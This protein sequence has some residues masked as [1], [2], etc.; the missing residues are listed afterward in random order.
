MDP[1]VERVVARL[2]GTGG[3]SA[4]VLGGSRA[5]GSATAESDYDIGLYSSRRRGPLDI[6]TLRRAVADLADPGSS[7]T[8]TEPGEW[9]RW[10]VGGAWLRVDGRPVDLLY[11]NIDAVGSVIADCTHGRLEVDYQPG[12][13][14]CFVSSIWMAEVAQCQVLH[15]ADGEMQ[16]LKAAVTPYPP[17]LRQATLARFGWECGFAVANAGK[18]VSRGDHGYIAGSLFRAF[19]CMA[20]ALHALNG[21]YLMNEKGALAL[22]ANLPVT[23]PR[24]A[25]RA[26]GVWRD[27]GAGD[28]ARALATATSLVA[29]FEQLVESDDLTKASLE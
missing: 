28:Y 5:R 3:V 11:R 22:A 8:V 14:H 6:D 1:I 23:V 15:D 9:G 16:R 20:H 18:A 29:A 13:P 25:E 24:L 21:V 27:L 7:F 19:A 4:I 26:D 17:A 12:H 2:A 10:V